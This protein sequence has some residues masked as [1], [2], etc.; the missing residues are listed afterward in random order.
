MW[1]DQRSFDAF[2]ES[3][4]PSGGGLPGHGPPGGIAPPARH[5][6]LHSF[7]A[8]LLAV[9]DALHAARVPIK[10]LLQVDDAWALE[11]ILAEVMNNIVEHGYGEEDEGTILLALS[12]QGGDLVCT[13][14]DFGPELPPA[15]LRGEHPPPDPGGLP[16]G[17]FGWFLIRDLAQD[18][19]Y[20]RVEGYNRLTLRFPLANPA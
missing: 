14:G 2:R 19:H 9:R 1:A 16:E 12:L 10:R 5:I 17:G 15:C 3:Q 18:L 8:T 11:L 7:R 6:H 4:A 13:V 20:D